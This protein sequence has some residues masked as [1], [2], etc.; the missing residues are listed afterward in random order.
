MKRAAR[1]ALLGVLLP[2]PLLPL[3]AASS[4]AASSPAASSPAASS[5]AASS[6]A[7]P[8]AAAPLAA[9]RARCPDGSA[10]RVRAGVQAAR[11]PDAISPAEAAAAGARLDRAMAARP[12]AA[13][14]PTR[15]PVYFHV[16]HDGPAGDV[17]AAT[18]YRQVN[19]LN[20]TFGGRTGG[21]DTGFRFVLRRIDRTDNASWYHHADENESAMKSRLHRGEAGTLNIYT[22]DLGEQLLGW[23]SFP[24]RYSSHGQSHAAL[25]GVVVHVAGLAGGSLAHYNRGYSATHETGHWLGLFHTFQN[26]CAAPGDRVADTPPEQEPGQGCPA[27]ARDTCP[28]PGA[29]PIHNFMDYSYDTC[30]TQFTPGQAERMRAAWATYR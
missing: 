18:V 5:P 24:W 8:L 3:L 27:G 13:A 14:R 23:A 12:P 29:D 4:P 30:M 6:P 16:I 15:V 25:D 10:D 21:A 11:D 2:L 9:G 22:A 28:A 1:F 7:A 19:V 26:G 20:E 17:P